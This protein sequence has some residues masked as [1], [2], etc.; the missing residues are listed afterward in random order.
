METTD[1]DCPVLITIAGHSN[2]QQ[3]QQQLHLANTYITHCLLTPRNYIT[4]ANERCLR[5]KLA[6]HATRTH[7]R[8]FISEPPRASSQ[9]YLQTCAGRPQLGS[10]DNAELS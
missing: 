4:P 8:I 3:R 7:P 2:V 10:A 1:A 5:R 6:L 9:T